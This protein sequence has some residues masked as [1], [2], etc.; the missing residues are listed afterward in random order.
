[1]RDACGPSLEGSLGTR[2]CGSP[3]GCA[4]LIIHTDAHFAANCTG[5]DGSYTC[6]GKPAIQTKL[7]TIQ[8]KGIHPKCT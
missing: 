3:E 8:L 2:V 4:D 6:L 5:S 7:K 1:M